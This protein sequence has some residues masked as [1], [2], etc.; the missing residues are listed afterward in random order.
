MLSSYSSSPLSLVVVDG[1]LVVVDGVAVVAAGAA[2]VAA[3]AAVVVAGA[4]VVVLL[5][6]PLLANWSPVSVHDPAVSEYVP[7]TTS[8]LMDVMDT[9]T[10]VRSTLPDWSTK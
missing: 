4:V 10:A 5:L 9:P 1:A 6:D 3:G 7:S 2:V 8:P